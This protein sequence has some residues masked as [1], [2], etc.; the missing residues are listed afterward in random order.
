M[1]CKLMEV[2]AIIWL[3]TRRAVIGLAMFTNFKCLS[4]F[5]L[6][7]PSSELASK[8]ELGRFFS[9]GSRVYRRTR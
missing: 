2:M 8:L 1:D 7:P 3:A 6:L 9:P 5:V 4:H